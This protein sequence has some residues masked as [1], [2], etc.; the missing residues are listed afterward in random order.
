MSVAFWSEALKS[1]KQCEVQP[2]E[3]YVLNLQ[4]A[5]L[6]D[7][8]KGQTTVVKAETLSITGDKISVVLC[9]LRPETCDQ[10]GFQ[11]VFGFDV[12]VGFSI[13]GPGTVHLAGY[14]QP[15]PESM[16]DEDDEDMYDMDDDEE[17]DE[18]DGEDDDEEVDVKK[19]AQ[20]KQIAASSK[21]AAAEEDDD[22]DEDEDDD[23]DDDDD[24]DDGVD[25]AFIK[26]IAVL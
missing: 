24:D 13:E 11:L 26:V 12:P 7:G 22:D 14:Y 17:D 16:D 19:A 21:A 18:D 8:K 15:G 10:F 1:G 23:E 3:G 2:P 20:Y 9:T 6:V 5:A 25:A 4:Q